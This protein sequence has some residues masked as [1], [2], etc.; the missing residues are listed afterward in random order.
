MAKV[1][2][3][4]FKTRHSVF[5]E[6]TNR[7]LFKLISQGHFEG[8][9]SPISVGKESNI[10]SALTKERKKVIVKIYRLETCDFRRMYHYIRDDPRFVN[11][12]KNRRD[13]IFAWCQREYRNLLR[14]R[15]AHVSAPLPIT[16]LNNVLVMEFV[17]NKEVAPKLKDFIPNNKKK[18]F[19]MIIKDIRK[20]YKLGF[21]HADL[22]QFNILNHNEVPVII[23]WSHCTPLKNLNSKELLE[24]DVR[25][26]CNFFRKIGL[27]VDE[28]KI[29]GKITKK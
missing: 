23:D 29:L 22:S 16:F 4:R 9:Q 21:V 3:E 28:K 26:I 27:K 11:L 7:T 8:L 2:K 25:N 12:G 10:F 24:R 17:G 5:D 6:F 13:V 18:L 15:E 19:G 1:V 14:A 20:L